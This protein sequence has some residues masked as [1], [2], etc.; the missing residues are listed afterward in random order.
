MPDANGR[1]LAANFSRPVYEDPAGAK[2]WTEAEVLA[3]KTQIESRWG[4]WR[5]AL[6]QAEIDSMEVR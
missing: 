1:I 5:T 6:S 2:E 3:A 4:W